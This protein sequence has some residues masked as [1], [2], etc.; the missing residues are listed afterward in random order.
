MLFVAGL[1]VTFAVAQ[2]APGQKPG[3]LAGVT[4]LDARQSPAHQAAADLAHQLMSPFCPGKLLADCT[5]PNAG[6]MRQ[7]IAGR[8]AAGETVDA[9]KVDLVRQYGA[10]ILGA[11]PAQGVGL[12]AW[13][14]PALLGIA[15]A[16]GIGWKVAQA[17]R[18][19]DAHPAVAGAGPTDA[20]ALA[21]LDDELRA[22]D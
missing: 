6:T 20:G 22:L 19:P 13:L 11:P 17:I 12:L 14:V 1:L 2:E 8:I 9:V 16:A 18:A 10:E 7:A 4:G 5:S 15:S 21:T 3:G